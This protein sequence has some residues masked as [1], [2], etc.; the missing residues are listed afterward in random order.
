[1][2][3]ALLLVT[4][5]AGTLLALS[6]VPSAMLAG[7]MLGA[8]GEARAGAYSQELA[9]Y[10]DD[11]LRIAAGVLLALV[12]GLCVA[13][14]ATEELVAAALRDAAWP[15]HWPS[16]SSLLL[17]GAP[18]LLA[19]ALRIPFL[20]QPMRYDEALTFNQFASR[21]L[22]YGLSFYP[23]PN[24]H[25]LNTLLMH[26]A[27]VGL[28]NQPW[29]LRVPALLGGVLLVP[30]TYWLARQLFETHAAF[31][32]AVLVATS[33]YLV[34]YSTN[35]RGYSL[36]AFFF[37]VLLSLVIFA[38][39][40]SS[41]SGLMLAAL[42][43]A[44]GAYAVPTMLYG[45]VVAGGWLLIELRLRPP[46]HARA[47]HLL[48]SGLIMGLA[49]ALLYVPV[50]IISG[51][52]KLLGNRFVVPLD[53]GQLA[54]DLPRSLAQTWA[55]WNRDIMLLLAALLLIGFA[56]GSRRAPVGLLALGLCVAMVLVQRVAPF[57]RVWLFLLPLYLAIAAG[58]LA[59]F[60][61]GRLLGIA[62]GVA[63]GFATLTSGSILR[64]TET[65]VFPDAE[66]AAH[67]LG[68][69][70]APDDAVMTTVPASLPELQ[71]Y[72]PRAGLPIDVLVRSPD[73]AQNLYVIAAT[74][75]APSINGW[76]NP[77]EISRLENASVYK[78][79]RVSA[80]R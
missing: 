12:A 29:V 53:L 47:T 48:A 27:F 76:Q 77:T 8:A 17:V 60:V 64:S 33:S 41:L 74:G 6:L 19:L 38:A 15:A 1:V 25:L 58:G 57:E 20:G 14:S 65:G 45:I 70:L 50:I 16:A 68:P 3:G 61:D 42:V 67:A 80:T 31:L 71:Y 36:Q 56:I 44:L 69:R 46:S 62:C 32:A 10:L 24:N 30:A 13:R 9:V 43:A 52:D 49:V 40:E 37:V 66:A 73:E 18:M 22:Y 4:L 35:A 11:R 21:P 75:T 39:R 63:M 54:T 34:E 59:R 79:S 5:L 28:G 7:R 26:L 55:L 2:V 72:F 23:D 78:L 51:P